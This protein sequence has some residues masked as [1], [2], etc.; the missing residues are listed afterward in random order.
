MAL[1]TSRQ[2]LEENNS[3]LI[4]CGRSSRTLTQSPPNTQPRQSNTAQRMTQESVRIISSDHHPSSETIRMTSQPSTDRL[5]TWELRE[6]Q[7]MASSR[8]GTTNGSRY[9]SSYTNNQPSSQNLIPSQ[10]T[11]GCME[12][13]VSEN[14][15]MRVVRNPASLPS[16]SQPTS[17]GM[18]TRTNHQSY[19]TTSVS[20]IH[21][22]DI[23]SRSGRITIRSTRRSRMVQRRLD[24]RRS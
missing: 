12:T 7:R 9:Q 11:N 2:H 5:S 16:T 20:S 15:N 6:L 21:V 3:D 23:T 13:Q 14:P 19:Q 17:G 24:P 10:S 8:Q 22:S 18:D 1:S 4:P